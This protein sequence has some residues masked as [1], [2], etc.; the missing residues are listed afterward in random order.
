MR[1][2]NLSVAGLEPLHLDDVKRKVCPRA[3]IHEGGSSLQFV[4]RSV[5]NDHEHECA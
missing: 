5:H 1:D 4:G 3:G 2:E